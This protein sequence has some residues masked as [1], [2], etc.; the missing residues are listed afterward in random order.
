[1]AEFFYYGTSGKQNY[2]EAIRIY[3]IVEDTSQSEI[4]SHALFQLGIAHQ[5]GQGTSVDN[6]VAQ[7]YYD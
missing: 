7:L 6:E 2:K 3:K 1:M 4:K 5:F